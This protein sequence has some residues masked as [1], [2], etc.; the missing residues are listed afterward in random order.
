MFV[1]P[2]TKRFSIPYEATK[3]EKEQERELLQGNEI[4]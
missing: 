3:E 2:K 1:H 4:E